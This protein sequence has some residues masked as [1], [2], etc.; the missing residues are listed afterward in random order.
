MHVT[1][2]AYSMTIGIVSVIKTA[3]MLERGFILPNYD[4]KKPNEKIPFSKWHLKVINYAP[5]SNIPA[6][7]EN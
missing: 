5:L 3:M 6:A 2:D 7:D 1:L 4:F